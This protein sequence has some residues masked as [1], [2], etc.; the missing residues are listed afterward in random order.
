M[1]RA[2]RVSTTVG[3]TRN[4]CTHLLETQLVQLFRKVL[5]GVKNGRVLL[6]KVAKGL[7][8][9]SRLDVGDL[10]QATG[11]VLS[12]VP[13]DL[14]NLAGCQLSNAGCAGAVVSRISTIHIGEHK[15]ARRAAGL[16]AECGPDWTGGW[17]G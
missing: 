4:L 1:W 7:G 9:S 17:E 3:R 12:E 6:Q 8:E 13:V 5:H 14:P 10:A 15:V 16:R 2:G 11:L